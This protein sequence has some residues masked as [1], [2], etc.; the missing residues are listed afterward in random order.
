M[1]MK[2]MPSFAILSIFGV[3]PAIMPRWYAEMFH[4]PTHPPDDEN[5]WL[6][7]LLGCGSYRGQAAASAA[8]AI[9]FNITRLLHER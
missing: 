2:S 8:A 4:I 6:V 9:S 7:W 3:S 1:S 5:I